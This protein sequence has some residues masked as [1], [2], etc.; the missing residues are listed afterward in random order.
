MTPKEL[1]SEYYK[2]NALHNPDV[3]DK[4]LHNDFVMQW[5]SS[6]GY[7]EADK[8]DGL[9]L[10]AELSKSYAS[11]HI[12]I[13]H[14][15]A[16]G[17]MVSVRYTHHVTTIENPSEEMVLAHFMVVWEIKDSKLHKAYLM[18]QLG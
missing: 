4:Y 10:A 7:F 12:A 5:Y 9:A 14:I 1:V 11:S 2:L 13:S 6:K 18:S 15:I 3:M 16:E 17:S 8:K